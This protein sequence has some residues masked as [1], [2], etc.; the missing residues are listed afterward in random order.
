MVPEPHEGRPC[1]NLQIDN[2]VEGINSFS[3]AMPATHR[4]NP[5]IQS[6]IYGGSNGDVSLSLEECCRQANLFAAMSTD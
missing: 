1:L 3:V 6:W 5:R 4:E 2:L